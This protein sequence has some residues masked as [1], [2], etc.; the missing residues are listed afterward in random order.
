MSDELERDVPRKFRRGTGTPSTQHKGSD[1]R[2]E[3]CSAC[4]VPRHAAQCSRLQGATGAEWRGAG[5]RVVLS[6]APSLHRTAT[7]CSCAQDYNFKHYA[8]RTVK[9]KF[10]A[11]ASAEGEAAQALVAEAQAQAAMLQRQALISNMYSKAT[12]VMQHA[13]GARA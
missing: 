2:R 5:A 4:T 3:V 12:S 7:P 13:A 6:A 8:V 1:E 11:G 9:A 10:R